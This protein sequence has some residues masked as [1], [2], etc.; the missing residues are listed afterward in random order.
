M[1]HCKQW[2]VKKTAEAILQYQT[3][4]QRIIKV[5]IFSS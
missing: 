5:H 4:S 3:R 2:S 1:L